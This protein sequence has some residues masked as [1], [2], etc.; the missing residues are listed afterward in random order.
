MNFELLNKILK[1]GEEIDIY[2]IKNDIY[3]KIIYNNIIYTIKEN[4]NGI[5]ILK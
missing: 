3:H 2:K 5:K 1:D 4:K